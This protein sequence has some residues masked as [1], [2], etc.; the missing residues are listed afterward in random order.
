MV[1]ATS[2]FTVEVFGSRARACSAYLRKGSRVVVDAEL[3]WREWTD[4]QNHRREAVTFGARQVLFEGGNTSSRA[5]DDD[6][7]DNGSSPTD[8]EPAG[9]VTPSDGSPGPDDLPFWPPRPS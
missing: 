8:G 3:D 9:A 1:D 4:Q 5:G 2:Y 7:A 6:D